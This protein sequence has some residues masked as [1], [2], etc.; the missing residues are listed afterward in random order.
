MSSN[1]TPGIEI[2]KE[3]LNVFNLTEFRKFLIEKHIITTAIGIVIGRQISKLT[4]VFLLNLIDPIFHSD[5]DGNGKDDWKN[6]KNMKLRMK[7]IEFGTGEIIL[8]VLKFLLVLYVVF[9]ISRATID[10]VD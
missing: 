2:E 10:I 8:G 7:G 4:D 3:T 1:F 9:L 5:I 6:I